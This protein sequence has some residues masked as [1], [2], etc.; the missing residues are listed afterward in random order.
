MS[1]SDHW[2]SYMN[3]DDDSNGG[4]FPHVEYGLVRALA[5]LNVKETNQ[6]IVI[7]DCDYGTLNSFK[8]EFMV[9]YFERN[10]AHVESL[11]LLF[12]GDDVSDNA[13]E[14]LRAYLLKTPL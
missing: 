5:G 1:D 6:V 9:D 7:K 4:L 13:A 10:A 12:C 2:D 14:I 11:A 3:E 8:M